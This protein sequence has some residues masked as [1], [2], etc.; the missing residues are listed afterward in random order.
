MNGIL[1]QANG[2]VGEN[3]MLNFKEV[4]IGGHVLRN[5]KATAKGGME[6]PLLL[7]Q[8]VL[9]EFSS[10]TQDNRNKLLILRK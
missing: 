8:S 6:T 9:S 2:E 3:L 7:G 4:E 1:H 5:I 10:V